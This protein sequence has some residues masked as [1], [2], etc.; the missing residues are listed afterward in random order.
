MPSPTASLLEPLLKLAQSNIA[1]WTQFLMAPDQPWSPG[2]IDLFGTR[3]TLPALLPA[4]DTVTQLWN[5]LVENHNRF[6]SEWTER[7]GQAFEAMP[8][9]VQQAVEPA[10]A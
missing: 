8:K 9:A 3:P 6:L 1:T 5:G 4:P 10:T 7:S 2:R